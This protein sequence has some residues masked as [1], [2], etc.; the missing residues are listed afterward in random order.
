MSESYDLYSTCHAIAHA[1]VRQ[2]K[3]LAGYLQF[4]A[5]RL[6]AD[7]DKAAGVAKIADDYWSAMN[8]VHVARERLKAANLL[9]LKSDQ[10]ALELEDAEEDERRCIDALR[11]VVDSGLYFKDY[12]GHWKIKND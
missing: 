9:E 10:F 11:A 12:Y 3:G 7:V 6:H 5:E 8:A 4:D 1:I 2:S